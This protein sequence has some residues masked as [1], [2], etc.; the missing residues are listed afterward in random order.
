MDPVLQRGDGSSQFP[1][2]VFDMNTQGDNEREAIISFARTASLEMTVHDVAQLRAAK[3]LLGDKRRIYVSHLPGQSWEETVAT[4][5]AVH[6]LGA[7][8]IP[9]VPVRRARSHEELQRFLGNCVTH[10]GVRE[11]LLIAGDYPQSVGPYATTMEVLS[12]GILAQHGI[13]RLSVAGHP[14]GHPVVSSD[15]LRRA[16]REKIEFAL[17]KHMPLTFLTQLFFAAQ[18]FIEW[19]SRLP[20]P[21]EAG[22]RIRV[23][24]GLAG[25]AKLTTLL[26]YAAICGV[27]PSMRALGTRPT[28]IGKMFTVRGPESIVH[29]LAATYASQSVGIHLY[30]FGGLTRTCAWLAAV[31]QG[32]FQIQEE[33]GF[34]VGDRE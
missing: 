33:Q 24:A 7:T 21:V 27:G 4:C 32:R 30:S 17:S 8:P 9:H 18:P 23:V 1:Q 28:S 16:E 15:E 13:E 10:A 19:R 34:V 5:T 26:R 25:P 29:T 31:A 11:I 2:D 3:E 12:T 14:E 20:I 6:A 22:D